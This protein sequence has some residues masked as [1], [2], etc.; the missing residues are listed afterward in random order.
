MEYSFIVKVKNGKVT[1]QDGDKLEDFLSKLD[2]VFVMTIT[3]GRTDQQ[4]KLYWTYIHIISDTTGEDPDRVH[5]TFKEK[6]LN[7]ESTS[8]ISPKRFVWY[9]DKIKAEMAEFG[10]VLPDPPEGSDQQIEK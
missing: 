1:F 5:R 10:I 7:K 8:T 9:L 3:E 4:N 6:Y 2:G